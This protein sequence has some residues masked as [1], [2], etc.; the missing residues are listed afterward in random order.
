MTLEIAFKPV[1]TQVVA[2][3]LEQRNAPLVLQC[4]LYSRN[5]AENKLILQCLCVCGNENLD[6]R[7]QGRHQ[8]SQCLARA[9]A[10]LGQQPA[11]IIQRIRNLASKCG[12]FR[13]NGIARHAL[14]QQPVRIKVL[15]DLLRKRCAQ[16]MSGELMS[17]LPVNVNRDT[18]SP[19]RVFIS[20]DTSDLFFNVGQRRTS[21]F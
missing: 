8:I 16:R 19:T 14:R 11:T 7:T 18:V 17:L 3:S 13:A 12:L 1:R 2:A 20:E 6:I 21:I 9:S 15:A 4:G 5:V 10:R